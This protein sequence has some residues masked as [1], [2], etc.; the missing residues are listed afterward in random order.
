[1]LHANVSVQSRSISGANSSEN[2]LLPQP[3]HVIAN[4]Q[5]SPRSV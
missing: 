4:R 5:Q 1:V 3:I 2:L